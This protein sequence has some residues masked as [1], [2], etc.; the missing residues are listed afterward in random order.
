MLVN[1]S[2]G[3]LMPMWAFIKMVK[4]VKELKFIYE[5][6]GND[7]W[8]PCGTMKRQA[9]YEMYAVVDN[10][11]HLIAYKDHR[12]S[13]DEVESELRKRYSKWAIKVNPNI[14]IS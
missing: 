3:F 1:K 4:S 14:K 10:V 12:R 7:E 6:K 2:K 9:T 5:D 8:N 13:H 11:L